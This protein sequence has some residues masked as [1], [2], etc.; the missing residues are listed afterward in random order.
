MGGAEVEAFLTHLAVTD[1]VAAATQN[2]ALSALLFLYREVPGLDLAWPTE[3][4]RAK[5][6][7]RLPV[8]LT[9]HEV[10]QVLERMEGSVYGLM[11]R[12]FGS[13]CDVERF[14]ATKGYPPSRTR[15]GKL[16]VA[17]LPCPSR[18]VMNSR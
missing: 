18:T 12:L 1:R 16:A 6:P 11:T 13:E 7:A 17:A 14:A 15:N 5:R 2:Q 10:T 4:V 3:V 8:V 9:R